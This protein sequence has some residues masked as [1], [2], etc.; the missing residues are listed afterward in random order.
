MADA[1]TPGATARLLGIAPSTLRS[2]D[3]RYGIGP[4]GR[5]PGGHR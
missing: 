1:L 3:H 2:W 5:S 4:R